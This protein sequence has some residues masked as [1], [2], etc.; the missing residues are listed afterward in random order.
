MRKKTVLFIAFC[1]VTAC[2]FATAE[3]RF[4]DFEYN[5]EKDSISAQST[6]TKKFLTV[7]VLPYG[8]DYSSA[9]DLQN[10]ENVLVKVIDGGEGLPYDI[11]LSENIG[12]GKYSVK[13]AGGNVKESYVFVRPSEKGAFSSFV[14]ALNTGSSSEF[15]KIL[16][17]KIYENLGI[18]TEDFQKLS[19]EISDCLY[20]FKPD[21]GYTAESFLESFVKYEGMILFSKGEISFEKLA[22]EYAVYFD[23]D[24]SDAFANLSS[25]EKKYADESRKNSDFETSGADKGMENILFLAR[26]K[27]AKSDSDLKALCTEKFAADKVDMSA[28]NEISNDYY[29]S[30]VWS[31]MFSARL[32]ATNAESVENYFKQRSEA[33]KDASY[34]ASNGGNGGSSGSSSGSKGGGSN[35]GFGS[36]DSENT[37]QRNNKIFADM[38]NHWAKNDVEKM[39]GLKIVNGFEDGTFRP[40]SVVTRAEFVK[41]LTAVMGIKAEGEC[42]FDDVSASDWYAPFIAAAYNNGLINGVG[43]NTFAPNGKILRQDAAAVVYRAIKEKLSLSSEKTVF[44]DENEISAYAKEAVDSLSAADIISG[45]GGKFYPLSNMTRAEAASLLLRIYNL[46]TEV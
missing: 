35:V 46:K 9:S 28:Y 5:F 38:E 14:S 2:I 44:S 13:I 1:L 21:G 39:Y 32:S 18:K 4:Y 25:D 37:S 26:Y 23:G 15:A 45:S 30:L 6:Q 40:E 27:G 3:A 11:L 16:S 17:G 10:G 7:A 12:C 43:E 20:N 8:K 36:Y 33:Q 31:D 24:I 42:G 41:M 34:A 29:K 19:P 22:S